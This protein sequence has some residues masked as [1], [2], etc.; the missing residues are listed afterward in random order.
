MSTCGNVFS[1]GHV[2]ALSLKKKKTHAEHSCFFFFKGANVKIFSE[3]KS[4]S[5]FCL[6]RQSSTAEIQKLSQLLL[7]CSGPARSH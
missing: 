4:K 5:S 6:W 2:M 1:K 7:L 3:A